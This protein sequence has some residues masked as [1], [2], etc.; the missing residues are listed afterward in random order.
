MVYFKILGQEIKTGFLN[1]FS[2]RFGVFFDLLLYL[3]LYC[4][5]LFSG[6][7]YTLVEQ[8]SGGVDAKTLVLS[9]YLLWVLTSSV[10][11]TAISDIQMENIKGTLQKKFMAVVPFQWLLFCMALSNVVVQLVIIAII[12]IASIIITGSVPIT[13]AGVIL[14]AISLVGM[15][16]MSL[17]VGAI[18]LEKKRIGQLSLLINIFLLYA[19]NVITIAFNGPII[20]LIPLSFAN[21][22][23]R[24]NFVGAKVNITEYV[25]FLAV[26]IFWCVI[27]VVIMNNAIKKAKDKGTLELF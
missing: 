20:K 15:Y 12:F 24:L 27:G 2:Y 10:F 11:Q 3:G 14:G 21:D 23:I 7:G 9:G 5:L 1:Y 26:N 18:V 8:Y 17:I 22:L 6:S 25:I 13:L 16:G 19:G 4:Y